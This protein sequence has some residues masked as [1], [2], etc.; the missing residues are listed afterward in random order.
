MRNERRILFKKNRAGLPSLL[1][2]AILL[3]F[4]LLFL[5]HFHLLL[6]TAAISIYM[7]YEVMHLRCACSIETPYLKVSSS[8]TLF[9]SFCSSFKSLGVALQTLHACELEIFI[10]ILIL[11]LFMFLSSVNTV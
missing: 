10:K 8:Q 5:L 6:A 11:F 3:L 7:L 2:V 9:C 4:P 1:V